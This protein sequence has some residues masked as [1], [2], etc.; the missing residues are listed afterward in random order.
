MAIKTFMFLI[1]CLKFYSSELNMDYRM[2]THIFRA[3]NS[4]SSCGNS[5]ITI[6]LFVAIGLIP[7]FEPS[8]QRPFYPYLRFIEQ[9]PNHLNNSEAQDLI[10]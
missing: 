8:S 6:P 10:K 7:S 3:I 4:V 1:D 2:L 9:L 5:N